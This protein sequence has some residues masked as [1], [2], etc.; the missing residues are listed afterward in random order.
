MGPASGDY[1]LAGDSPC[2]DAGDNG[3]VPFEIEID[4]AGDPRFVDDP[5]TPDTGLGGPPIVDLGAFEYQGPASSCPADLDGDSIVGP[6]DLAQLLGAWGATGGKGGPPAADLD[7]DGLVGA[8]DLAMLLGA[9]G[10]C[11]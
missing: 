8:G 9:W 10:A 6:S 7:G 5:Q 11:G 4:L 3:V 1:A 2:I